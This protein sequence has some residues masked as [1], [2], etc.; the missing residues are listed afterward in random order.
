MIIAVV[1][2]GGYFWFMWKLVKMARGHKQFKKALFDRTLTK[3]QAWA[4]ME[5]HPF[6]YPPLVAIKYSKWIDY[7]KDEQE[8]N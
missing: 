2:V 8:D 1:I 4:H 7:L 5:R 3:Q 6:L